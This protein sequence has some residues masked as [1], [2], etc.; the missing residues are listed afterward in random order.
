MLPHG[1][2]KRE[3][4][5]IKAMIELYCRHHHT[6][7]GSLCADCA[8]LLAYAD[9][10]LKKCRFQ[11]RKTT[12]AKCPVHCYKPEMRD[13]VRNVMRYSGPLM[14]SRHP[15]MALMHTVDG[16]RRTPAGKKNPKSR[17]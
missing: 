7:S 15:V 14:L 4:D 12:C 8:E 16:L 10:R 13:K 17:T 11:E 5:T 2:M 3:A 6:D 1:R 9:R